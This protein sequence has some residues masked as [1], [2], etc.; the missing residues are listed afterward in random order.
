MAIQPTSSGTLTPQYSSDLSSY[1]TG[2]PFSTSSPQQPI[3]QPQNASYGSAD[4][5]GGFNGS[6]QTTKPTPVVSSKPAQ[7]QAQTIQDTASQGQEQLDTL[8]NTPSPYNDV[9]DKNG[10]LSKTRHSAT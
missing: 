6:T 8:A 4:L 9:R 3:T 1:N 5:S 2:S 10:N 7:S